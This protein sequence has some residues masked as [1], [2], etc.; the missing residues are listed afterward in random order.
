MVVAKCSNYRYRIKFVEDLIKILH[1][2]CLQAKEDNNVARL[3]EIFYRTT[4]IV[5]SL[6][7]D[8][9]RKVRTSMTRLIGTLI[10]LSLNGK[11]RIDRVKLVLQY[12][13]GCELDL[14]NNM[15]IL[16]TP[17]VPST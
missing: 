9:V 1:K 11:I 13:V 2:V 4:P 6:L 10:G 14:D 7:S 5:L 15:R 16:L 8:P 17:L 3:E 12:V